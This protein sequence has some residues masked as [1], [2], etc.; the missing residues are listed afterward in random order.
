MFENLLSRSGISL[1]RL[2]TF[3]RVAETGG[4]TKAA[5]GDPVRQS[6]YS[7]QIRE[8]EEFFGAELKRRHGKGIVLTE[9]GRELARLARAQLK[10]LQDF[11]HTARAM[12]KNLSIAAG[13]SVLEWL[14]LPHLEML[15]KASPGVRFELHSLRT[16][17][18]IT[19]L[20]DLALDIGIVREDA[21]ERPLV[22]K[23][24]GSLYSYALFVPN[25][26]ARGLDAAS[27][28]K[29][30]PDIPIATSV[31]G[32]FREELESLSVKAKW[33]LRIEV[34]CSSFTQAARA[35]HAG[36]CAAVLPD[37]AASD[38]DAERVAQFSL[39]FLKPYARKLALAWNPRLIE[40]RP[41][42]ADATVALHTALSKTTTAVK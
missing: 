39:P 2:E 19:K 3:C 31:G 16:G 28:R 8:L 27:L 18:T 1:D 26:I 4:I 12:P 20:Q 24:V 33:K 23:R 15:R 42:V 34:S 22:S 36:A 10:G 35:V 5:G 6:L 21:V 9:A 41:F 37:I 38:F 14:V 13:N 40:V 11:H 25:R 32:Q 29:R 17:E 7:R 30:L